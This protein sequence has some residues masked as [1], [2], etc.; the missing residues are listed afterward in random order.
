MAIKKLWRTLQSFQL[1]HGAVGWFL[2][3]HSG[4]QCGSSLNQWVISEFSGKCMHH[5]GNLAIFQEQKGPPFMRYDP[6]KPVMAGSTRGIPRNWGMTGGLRGSEKGVGFVHFW[7]GSKILR[8]S[9]FLGLI[10]TAYHIEIYWKY[11]DIN[12]ILRCVYVMSLHVFTDFTVLFYLM[13]CVNMCRHKC[14]VLGLSIR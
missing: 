10:S 13:I 4:G 6:G 11:R 12:R 3:H 5:S 14:I 7:G 2:P 8:T 9:D 1:Q